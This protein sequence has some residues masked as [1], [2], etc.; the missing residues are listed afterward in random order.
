LTFSPR[1]LRFRVMDIRLYFPARP[2]FPPSTVIVAGVPDDAD[3]K[4]V[5]TLARKVLDSRAVAPY[6]GRV[7]WAEIEGAGRK[8]GLKKG[9]SKGSAKG[10]KK[11]P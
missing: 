4:S 1:G 3:Q 7:G 5:E 10:R 8:L 2:G 9:A 6:M 11:S